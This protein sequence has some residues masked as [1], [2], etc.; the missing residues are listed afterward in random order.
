MKRFGVP[1]ILRIDE[2]KGWSSQRVREW[3]TQRGVT[4]EVQPAENHSWLG[5]VERKHQVVR[6]ALS[7]EVVQSP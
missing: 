2:A 5:V 3:A 1:K 7:D 4:L 6:R